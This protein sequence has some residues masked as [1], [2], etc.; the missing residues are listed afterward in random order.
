MNAI[1]LVIA[2]AVGVMIVGLTRVFPDVL[3]SSDSKAHLLYLVMLLVACSGALVHYRGRLHAGL[4]D[5][6]IWLG[7]GAL[8]VLGYSFRDEFGARLHRELVPSAL[9]QSEDGNYAVR[10]SA[11]GHYYLSAQVNDTPVRFMVDTGASGVVLPKAL[12]RKLGIPLDD[13]EFVHPFSTANGMA[14]H[15]RVILD[16]LT[17]GPKT[18]DDVEAFVSANGLDTPLLGISILKR[19]RAFRF[20]GQEMIL[21]F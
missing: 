21:T 12:A 16:R 7:L 11:D 15:A 3:G 2:L 9:I 5:A 6:G 4:R 14:L 19:L 1:W 10:A 8:L 17:L 18:F 20:E 13:L